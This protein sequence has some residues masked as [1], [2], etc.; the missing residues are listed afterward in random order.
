MEEF[1]SYLERRLSGN[2]V[3]AYKTAIKA[4]T[5]W[6]D[7]REPAVANAQEFLDY[8]EQ[9]GRKPN[10]IC[11]V[12]NAIRRYFRWKTGNRIALDHT[13]SQIGEPVYLTKEQFEKV[14]KACQTPLEKALIYGLYDTACRI[15]E[16]M[17]ITK[18]D[19]DWD[20]GFIRVMRKGGRIAQVNISEK[21]MNALD[22]FLSTRSSKTGRVFMDYTYN[23]IWLTIR[24]VGKRAG[25]DLHP[26]ML[27]HTRAVHMLEA[28]VAL[29]IIQLHLGHVNIGT[30][31]NIYARLR[32][33]DLK[34]KI[35]SW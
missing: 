5:L 31:A 22:E 29:N 30:T 35:P 10:G 13:S 17:N 18:K 15:G 3:R 32:P 26:H 1:Y 4:Y 20:S 25:I 34:E 12:A 19:I 27:R 28:G 7:G 11:L 16:F 14:T 21:A 33:V 9:K 24:N 23:D 2:S 6:L 8:L